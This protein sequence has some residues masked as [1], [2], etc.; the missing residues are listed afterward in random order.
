[1]VRS[2]K[3]PD[4]DNDKEQTRRGNNDNSS[5]LNLP[6]MIFTLSKYSEV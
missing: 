5:F 1:M 2:S 6:N 3:E 4:Y